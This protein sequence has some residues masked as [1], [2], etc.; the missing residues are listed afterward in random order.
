M[1]DAFG[2]PKRVPALLPLQ[3]RLPD[4]AFLHHPYNDWQRWGPMAI[5]GELPGVDAD[6]E[7]VLVDHRGGR[8]ERL[9]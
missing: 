2:N 5:A 4:G 3:A 6:K 7:L 9:M 1:C 8:G